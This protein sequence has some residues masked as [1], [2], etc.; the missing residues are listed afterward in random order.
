[1][2]VLDLTDETA[3]ARWRAGNQLPS[4]ERARKLF[5]FLWRQEG[6]LG[7][8]SAGPDELVRGALRLQEAL[9]PSV[10]D[11]AAA[12]VESARH[13]VAELKRLADVAASRVPG[14]QGPLAVAIKAIETRLALYDLSDSFTVSEVMQSA[15]ENL[16][17]RDMK[18]N[19]GQC[20]DDDHF[21]QEPP[22]LQ[23]RAVKI[24]SPPVP[25]QGAAVIPFARRSK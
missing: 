15:V 21:D 2:A 18:M 14:I 22:E 23:V 10:G 6:F 1:M 5:V 19:P 3:W 20:I 11:E 12:I 17:F 4:N 24:L 16:Y 25:G 8:L 9:D 7:T 13:D